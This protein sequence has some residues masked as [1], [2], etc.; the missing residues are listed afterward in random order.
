[1]QSIWQMS[2]N[3][4]GYKYK[5]VSRLPSFNLALPFGDRS[6]Y[7]SIC[8]NKRVKERNLDHIRWNLNSNEAETL[9]SKSSNVWKH[10][11]SS[12]HVALGLAHAWALLQTRPL[13]LQ[14]IQRLMSS[15]CRSLQKKLGVNIY[16]EKYL[17]IMYATF[18]L[19]P[20]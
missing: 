4:F 18:T 3:E 6:L 14:P 5:A 12:F 17:V 16:L 19:V 1:M 7:T 8:R 2:S 9:A 11:T 15:V 10:R 20:L 13:T